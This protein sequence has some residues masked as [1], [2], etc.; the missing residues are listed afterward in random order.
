MFMILLLFQ[1]DSNIL[2]TCLSHNIVSFYPPQVAYQFI[3]L[4][5]LL[6]SMTI[7]LEIFF[8]MLCL[9]FR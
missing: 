6:V 5:Y 4:K 3:T 7:W 8:S 1:L 9:F 2:D